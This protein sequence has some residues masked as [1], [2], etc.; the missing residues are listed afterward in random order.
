MAMERRTPVTRR[1]TSTTSASPRTTTQLSRTGPRSRSAPAMWSGAVQTSGA[2][3]T[4]P[5]DTSSAQTKRRDRDCHC[6]T[7]TCSAAPSRSRT[8][9]STRCSSPPNH[10]PSFWAS[11]SHRRHGA[12]SPA[13]CGVSPPSTP[14]QRRVDGVWI[15]SKVEVQTPR[16]VPSRA[17]VPADRAPARRSA[18]RPPGD[19]HG[20][21]GTSVPALPP[22][23]E[24]SPSP[25][26]RVDGV[27][28]GRGTPP[29][30]HRRDATLQQ[31]RHL[32][33]RGG[34]RG[35]RRAAPRA[36]RADRARAQIGD[37]RRSRR[38]RVGV[39]VVV[40]RRRGG[41]GRR[42][43]PAR[44]LEGRVRVPEPERDAGGLERRHRRARALGAPGVREQR[45]GAVVRDRVLGRLELRLLLD[46]ERREAR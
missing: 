36:H 32:R 17:S 44:P 2:A 14:S 20:S 9:T 15:A 23:G 13:R 16:R 35:R 19:G 29:R 12:P 43:V 28:A 46:G 25:I 45:P 39:V 40:A 26:D 3:G 37:A 21:S 5:P 10:W 18:A 11:T 27:L 1:Q 4:P 24:W 31:R 7:T 6:Q 41:R 34:T 42:V 30:R 8:R 33:H 38:H 22:T